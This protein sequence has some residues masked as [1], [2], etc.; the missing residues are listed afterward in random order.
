MSRDSRSVSCTRMRSVRWLDGGND[1]ASCATS[2]SAP[3]T[4]VSGARS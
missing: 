1:P 2:S 4:V 3:F